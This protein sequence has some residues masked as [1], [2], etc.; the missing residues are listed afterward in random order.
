MPALYLPTVSIL[1]TAVSSASK[2][3]STHMGSK[4]VNITKI[5]ILKEQSILFSAGLPLFLIAVTF[6]ANAMAMSLLLLPIKGKST[7]MSST[8]AG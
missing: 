1:R 8:I 6:I 4:A 5:A 3:L 2:I 7:A